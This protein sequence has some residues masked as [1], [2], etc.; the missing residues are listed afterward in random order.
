LHTSRIHRILARI[1]GGESLQTLDP[2][3][4]DEPEIW[5]QLLDAVADV[6]RC[7]IWLV[8]ASFNLPVR[9]NVTESRAFHLRGCI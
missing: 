9:E 8:S 1:A 4:K 7:S 6:R 3:E 2:A 5:S